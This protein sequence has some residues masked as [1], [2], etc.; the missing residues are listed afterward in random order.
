MGSGKDRITGRN[1]AELKLG[2]GRKGLGNEE[3][4]CRFFLLGIIFPLNET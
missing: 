4:V 3:L 2:I 1:W